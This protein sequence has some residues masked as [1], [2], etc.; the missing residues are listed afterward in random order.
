MSV[1][2]ADL[3]SELGAL[4]RGRG[5]R[6]LRTADEIGPSLRTV[7]G[8]MPSDSP[9]EI[10]GKIIARL[11]TLARS[12]PEDL[13]IVA[14][15]AFA[16][17]ADASQQFLK[18]R[19]EWAAAKLDRDPRTVRRR[20]D[21][22]I[23]AIARLAASKPGAVEMPTP[24]RDWHTEHVSALLAL[25]LPQPEAFELRRICADRNGLDEVDLALTLTSADPRAEPLSPTEVEIHVFRGGRLR[26]V[27]NESADR[28]ALSIQLASQ[29][30]QGATQLI[31]LRFRVPLGRPMQPHYVCVPKGRCDSFELSVRFG[32]HNRP[33]HLWKLTDAL[34]RDLTDPFVRGDPVQL[35]MAGEVGVDFSQLKPGMAYGLRWS[36]E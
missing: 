32:E 26:T 1:V 17:H 28:F 5:V 29:L 24:D 4:R 12:L 10:Q 21:S 18:A 19:I 2:V 20:L 34:Q 8:V 13:Q 33:L 31:A 16:I 7:C 6:D 14:L 23:E 36:D 30:A 22:A 25:D 3:I 27:R 15:A 35:D 11:T 9:K